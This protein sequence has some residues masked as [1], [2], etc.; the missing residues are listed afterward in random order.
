MKISKI[1]ANSKKS[2]ESQVLE[3]KSSVE[4]FL[5]KGIISILKHRKQNFLKEITIKEILQKVKFSNLQRF[6][7]I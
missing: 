7:V 5:L 3:W 1:T 2:N 4:A 6:L